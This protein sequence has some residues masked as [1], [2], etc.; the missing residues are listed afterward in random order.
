MI[1]Q[2]SLSHH[3]IQFARFL[4]TKKFNVGPDE[5][6]DA[7]HGLTI[8]NW[9]DPE[10]FKAVLQVA[11]CKSFEQTRS[12][13]KWYHQY[14]SELSRA[15]DSK[16]RQEQE[17]K[18]RLM[19]EKRF[20]QLFSEVKGYFQTEEAEVYRKE[21]QLIVRLKAMQFPVG[22]SVIMPENYGLLSTVQRAIR[23]F[24]EPNVVIEGHT[25]STGSDEVNEMLGPDL[26]QTPWVVD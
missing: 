14:W 7:L 11:F 6:S 3:I 13:E 2:T 15:V 23:I 4:R 19:A 25:D 17:V 9:Q 5:V 12:F 26:R 1:R 18:E 24:G 21:N 20:N 22:Q 10:Q 16:T 8:I